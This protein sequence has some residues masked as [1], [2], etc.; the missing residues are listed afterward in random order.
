MR[1]DSPFFVVAVNYNPDPAHEA[2]YHNPLLV[3]LKA[4]SS[5]A[6]QPKY[7]LPAYNISPLSYS[8]DLLS[9]LELRYGRKAKQLL[10]SC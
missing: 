8:L 7:R 5:N 6:K 2:P 1:H 10:L 3:P 9:G 4:T